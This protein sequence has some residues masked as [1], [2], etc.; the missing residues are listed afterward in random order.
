MK[1]N[2]QTWLKLPDG[3]MELVQ[4]EEIEIPDPAP[5]IED[6]V[7]RILARLEA[8]ESKSTGME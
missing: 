1:I 3:T 4:E 2:N 5:T 7:L 6:L 8:L